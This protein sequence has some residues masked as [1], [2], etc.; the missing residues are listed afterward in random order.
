[1][2]RMLTIFTW[3]CALATVALGQGFY[4]VNEVHTIELSFSQPDWD[5]ILDSLFAAGNEQ[6][7][8]ATA[9][10]DGVQFDSVGVR[11]KGPSTYAIDRVKSPLNIKLDYVYN[12]Q[13]IEGFGTLKLANV[14]FD[15]SFLREVL[16]YEIA[17]KYMPASLANYANVYVNGSLIG[18][19]VNVQDVDKLFLQT[20]F[21]SKNN[22]CFKGEIVG[23]PVG[24]ASWGYEGQDSADYTTM[25]ELESD[26]G[27]A[28]LIDFLDTLNN[29]TSAVEKVLNV[30][31][32]LWMLAYDNLLV[33]LDAPINFPHNYYLYRDDSFRFNPIIWDLNMN[34]GGYNHLI[35]LTFL[36]IPQLQQV[37]PFLNSTNS[38]YPILNKILPNATYQKKYIAHMKT[39]MQEN[40]SNNWYLM[41]AQQLRVIID[42]YVQ[43]DTNK[44]SSYA[45]YLANLN[46]A[47]GATPGIVQ[48]M[49]AR[50]S[51]LN[52]LPQ[53]NSQAP[54]ITAITHSPTVV[55]ANSTCWITA[56]VSNASTV[57]LAY[58]DN[59]V[60]Q[61]ATVAM[62]DDG[63][64]HDGN[65]A[66]EVYGAAI[67]AGSA[68]IHYYI[69]SENIE[70]GVFAPERAE[71]EDSILTVVVP[72]PP[73][74][75]INEFMADNSTTQPDQD[76]EFDDWIELHNLSD[77]T[78]SLKNFHLS[79][80]ASNIGKW[81][82]P[83]TSIAPH[84]Y[85]IIWADENGSQVGLHANFKLSASGEAV[86][87]SDS[88][89]A[90]VDSVSFGSQA[91]DIS[92]GRCPDGTGAFV[93][94]APSFAVRNICPA[95]CGD[96]DGSGD[97]DIAD[98]VY[99]VAYI[100]AGGSA[101]YPL[102]TG[103]ADCDG[104]ITIADAVYLVNYIFSGGQEPGSQC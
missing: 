89:P 15:P 71:Y 25:Y 42:Q 74:I 20:H 17:R 53:I 18:L 10:I 82:F 16:G 85:L 6:R 93:A 27:W 67:A 32:H 36:T 52:G 60:S 70:A 3:V 66:D 13:N 97:I 77:E 54:S 59:P 104:E 75:V 14:W 43:A 39:I 49:S 45:N 44:Y 48:L 1:M 101:P 34:L 35:P 73:P 63:A 57:Q 11:Y 91:L 99:M 102:S 56:D 46:S 22:A 58:R 8:A 19:Y 38:N 37:D 7:L 69:Y 96:A 87:L 30:D 29:F 51:Y 76:G 103:D 88:T 61:F 50:V 41:R 90:V 95:I 65:A 5:H 64:H 62:L 9:T 4:D 80:K 21:L 33:N 40:F 55:P 68:D 83:D 12:N 94:F 78:I 79:D 31:R 24:H 84:G 98:A 2:S 26:A 47:V 72:T 28:E 92:S 100:F 23:S 81:T 86:I